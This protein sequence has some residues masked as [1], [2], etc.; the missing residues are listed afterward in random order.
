MKEIK[1]YVRTN[2]V[3]HVIDELAKIP[4]LPGIAVV[5]LRQYGHR[6]NDDER[7]EKVA[8]VK[9]E[10]DVPDELSDEIVDTIVA[11]ARTKSGHPGD[12]RVFVS[13]PLRAVRIADGAEGLR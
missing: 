2:M 9:L 11:H 4:G 3:D 5:E 8:M 13:E 6:L 10:I 1:A 12:G 7:L